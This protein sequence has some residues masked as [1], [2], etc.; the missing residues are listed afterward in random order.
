MKLQQR[1]RSIP[2]CCVHWRREF[3]DSAVSIFDHKTA[4][5]EARRKEAQQDAEREQ[6]LQTIGQLTMERDFL[7]RCFRKAGQ[8]IPDAGV[9]RKE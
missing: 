7:Q 2:A 8:P 4:E 1:K 5:K 6:M 3:P 9:R